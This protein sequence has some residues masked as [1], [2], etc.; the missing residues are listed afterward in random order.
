MHLSETSGPDA[1]GGLEKRFIRWAE[2]DSRVE[3]FCKVHEHRHQ[4]MRRPYPKAD[5]MPAQY[6]PDFIVRTDGS[7]FV[8]ETKAQSAL[9][10]ENVRRKERA[11]LGWVEQINQLEPHLRMD[12]SWSYVLLGEE[13]V[14][15]WEAKGMR[16]SEALEMARLRRPDEPNQTT[17]F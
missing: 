4:V 8:V 7:I 6:S 5:G 17:I 16:A 1:Q 14:K 12:A 9:S 3:T 13:F 2:K 10:D 15:N 11:A